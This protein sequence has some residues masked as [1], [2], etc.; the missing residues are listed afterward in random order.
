MRGPGMR[1]AHTQWAP[2]VALAVLTVVSALLAVVLP[3]RIAGG[4]DRAAAAAVGAGADVRVEGKSGG[5]RAARLIPNMAAMTANSLAWQNMLPASLRA[6]TGEPEPSVTTGRMS[7]AGKAPSPRLLYLSWAEGAAERIRMV[8]GKPPDN[9]PSGAEDEDAEIQV[10]IAEKYADAMGYKPGDRLSLSETGV[11][12]PVRVQISGLYEPVNAAD[13]YWKPRPSMLRATRVS[14]GN[15]VPADLGTALTG[16]GGYT[17]LTRNPARRLTYSWRYPIHRDAVDSAT[18]AAIAADLDA[19]RSAVQGRS[20]M[21]SCRVVTVLDAR[22]EGY[23]GRL[24]TARSVLGLALGGLAAVA[25]GV[26]LLAAGLLGERLRPVLGTMRARGASLPQLAGPACGLTALAVL[27][28]AGLGYAAGRLLDTGPPQMTS[29]YAIAVLVA[30]VLAVSAAMVTRERGGGLESAADRRADVAAARPSRRRLVLD[31]LLVTLAVIGTVLLRRRGGSAGTDPLIAAVPALLGA[32]LGVLVLR[33]YP[34]LL[35]AAGPFLRR[36]RGAVAFLGLARA[37]RQNLVGTLPL[38]V[39]LLA[40]AI[41]GFTATVDTALR[42]GQERASWS[43]VGADAFIEAGP[44]D[45]AALRRIRAVRGVT[46][47]V[48]A[49]VVPRVTAAASERVPMTVIAV[50]LDAYRKLVPDMTGVPEKSGVWVSASVSRLLGKGTVTLS[51]P[52]LD[53]LRVTPSGRVERF[54]GVSAGSA[55]VI[56]PYK[57]LADAEGFPSQ[58][59]VAGHDLDAKALRA[60]APDRDVRMRQDVLDGLAGVPLV[61]VVQ[62]M[63]R[64]GALIGGG[65]GFL[66]VLLVLVVGARGRGRTVAHLRALG[67]SRRQSRGLALVEIAPV[68]LCAVGAGWV[69]GLLLPEITGPVVDLRPYTGGF[70]VTAY[71]PGVPALLGLLAGLLLAAAAAVAIDRVFDARPGTVLRTGE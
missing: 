43:K 56:V 40:A 12:Q 30:A 45:E 34:Y 37:A 20:N 3:A 32:A 2:L 62:E 44:L 16:A 19:Y 38:V 54:P 8:A 28:S 57:M 58:V 31:L 41:A 11:E 65:Y 15:G 1:L 55:F 46:G 67:L 52:G 22:L 25:A 47:A 26:L 33:A 5:D 59:F 7:I 35:R 39:L 6:V 17:M 9:R 66:A 51:R 14:I 64:D 10:V 42:D 61:T 48:P 24:H 27:P 13:E 60:A 69:L 49:R 53:P 21:F 18:A 68:L 70:A 50:D 29:V 4:Y 36:R 71:L 23:T 63:F